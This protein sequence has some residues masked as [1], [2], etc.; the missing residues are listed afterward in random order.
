MLVDDNLYKAIFM[1]RRN[2]T[3]CKTLLAAIEERTSFEAWPSTFELIAMT[4]Y[5]PSNGTNGI[6]IMPK[7]ASKV[8]RALNRLAADGHVVRTQ[9]WPKHPARWCTPQAYAAAKRSQKPVRQ[10]VP[11]PY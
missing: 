10:L 1:R 2:D 4:F 6:I 3:I 11:E 7:E 8:R 5:L 9:A